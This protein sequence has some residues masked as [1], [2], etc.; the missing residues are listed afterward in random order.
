MACWMR[1]SKGFKMVY[2]LVDL[3]MTKNRRSAARLWHRRRSPRSLALQGRS[4][5]GSGRERR[6]RGS[7]WRAEMGAGGSAYIG[8]GRCTEAWPADIMEVVL[9][10]ER[11]TGERVQRVQG[12]EA[13]AEGAARSQGEA[14]GDGGWSGF[15][16]C[17]RACT[18]AA[19]MSRMA[20]MSGAGATWSGRCRASP[21]PGRIGR[22]HV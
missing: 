7:R 6:K 8:R 11:G 1:I 3:V 10:G 21:C 22:A 16:A 12:V 17:T 19:S 9:Q 5:V 18:R 15:C 2:G 14:G 4:K 13:D 20:S